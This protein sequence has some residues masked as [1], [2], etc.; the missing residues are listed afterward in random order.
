M[1]RIARPES[2]KDDPGRSSLGPSSGERGD[3]AQKG[4]SRS[5]QAIERFVARRPTLCLGT[6]LFFGIALGWWVKRK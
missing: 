3:A 1:I 4:L 6:A 2:S 5:V